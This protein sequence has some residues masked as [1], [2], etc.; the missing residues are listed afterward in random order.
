MKKTIAALMLTGI[1]LLCSSE[2]SAADPVNISVTGRV[3]ASPCVVD[4]DTVSKQVDLGQAIANNL[5][6]PG[7]NP[8]WKD[9]QLLLTQC[10]A[11]TQSATATFTGV[12]D[13]TD[14]TAFKN[15]GTAENSALQMTN[16][17]HSVVYGN[18]SQMTVAVDNSTR[19]AIFPLSAR[20][21]SP[22][23]NATGGTFSA[24]V[25]VVF[26]YQ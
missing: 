10:P 11:A 2:A 12:V 24:A 20:I 1:S 8:I 25:S 23:E 15:Q 6:Q 22:S 16:T 4:T 9:F 14:P 7:G 21:F 5:N 3:V 17:D 26:T 18:A 13:S 19:R